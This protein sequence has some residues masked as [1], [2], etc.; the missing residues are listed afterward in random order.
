[1]TVTVISALKVPVPV[2]IDP[3][4]YVSEGKLVEGLCFR[5]KLD[6]CAKISG[7]RIDIKRK[8]IMYMYIYLHICLL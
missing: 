6:I 7:V 1:M 3:W 5:V 4:M 2:L 8:I